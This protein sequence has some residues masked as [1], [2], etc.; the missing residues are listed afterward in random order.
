MLV[1]WCVG[2]GGCEFHVHEVSVEVTSVVDD[3]VECG[4]PIYLLDIAENQLKNRLLTL[5]YK[6]FETNRLAEGRLRRGS[7]RRLS[8]PCS[9]LRC[10][11][12]EAPGPRDAGSIRAGCSG[13]CEF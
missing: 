9:A 2:S 10:L 4:R 3:A 6:H 5:D 7:V 1:A 13:E 11:Q 12:T 8:R